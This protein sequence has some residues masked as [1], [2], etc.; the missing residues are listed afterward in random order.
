MNYYYYIA[1][2][3]EVSRGA[4]KTEKSCREITEELKEVLSDS[5]YD[6][7]ELL[8]E[9]R[10]APKFVQWLERQG[11]NHEEI[12]EEELFGHWYRYGIQQRNRFLSEWFSFNLNLNNVLTAI[13]CRENKWDIDKHL[14]GE[15]QVTD[16]MRE[17][18]NDRDFG[19]TAEWDYYPIVAQIAA[20]EDIMEKEKKID[21][22]KWDWIEE[23]NTFNTFSVEVV[24]G[25]YLKCEMVERWNMLNV[26]EGEKAFRAILSKLTLKK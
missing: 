16:C 6:M 17:H 25:H 20:E 2:M 4:G 22:L 11:I 21:A 10:N 7:I 23:M 19:L 3:Q 8:S 5:D 13:I 26:E 12:G 18:I 15:S 24:M 1:G 9:K 14:V